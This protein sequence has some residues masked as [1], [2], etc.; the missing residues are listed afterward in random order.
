MKIHEAAD[1]IEAIA[2]S[3]TENPSQFH[4]EINVIGT[5][6]TA[7]GGGTGIFVQTSGGGPG[8]QTTG[9]QSSMNGANIEIAQKLADAAIGQEMSKLVD[10]LKNVVSELR[11]ANPDKT[12]ISAIVDSLKQSWIPNVITSVVASII[13]ATVLR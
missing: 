9:F 8:S 5:Q 1:L 10:T 6:G 3:I 4:F 11:S 7:I 13:S 12:R 2:K